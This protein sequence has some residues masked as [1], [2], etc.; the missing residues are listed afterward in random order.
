MSGGIDCNELYEE[1]SKT[2][3]DLKKKN[4]YGVHPDTVTQ[5]V[6]GIRGLF[7]GT[8]E[9]LKRQEGNKFGKKKRR[10]TTTKR[11]KTTKKRR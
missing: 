8:I 3:K 11:K 6:Q 9:K 7:M 5:Q 1:L 10:K 4:Y 2:I